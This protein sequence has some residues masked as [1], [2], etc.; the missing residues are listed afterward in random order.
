[1][2]PYQD[3]ETVATVEVSGAPGLDGRM[4]RENMEEFGGA[5]VTCDSVS[6]NA[7]TI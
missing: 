2:W 5:E 4:N 7:I 6:M 3:G 1:M